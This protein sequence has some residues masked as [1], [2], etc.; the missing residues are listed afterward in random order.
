MPAAAKKKKTVEEQPV[1]E[2]AEIE[3]AP[4]LTVPRFGLAEESRNIW[5]C[6]V[7]MGTLPIQV[8]DETF[9]ANVA[10]HFQP[11]DEIHV[12]PDD[13]GWRR[14]LHVVANGTNWAQVVLLHHHDLTPSKAPEVVPSKY[15]IEFA[16][17][18]HKWRVIREGE[19]LKDG[20][21]SKDLAAKWAA[22]HEAAVN[23]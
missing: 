8:M 7:P 5:R 21:A 3:K 6:T 15:K 2:T 17:A 20:F 18:H 14:D 10:M 4:P 9:W 12:L 11:G 19:P 16:G 13:Y 1:E 23:R 22:N